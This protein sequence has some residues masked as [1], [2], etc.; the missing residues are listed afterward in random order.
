MTGKIDEATTWFDEHQYEDKE[1][2]YAKQKEIEEV[3]NQIMMKMYQNAGGGEGGIPPG[4]GGMPGGVP[5]D[6]G[7]MA[8][9]GV[10]DGVPD[11]GG[12]A[13]PKIEEV[14]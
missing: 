11:M 14:D 4:M 3:A 6:M 9:G 13:G 1:A 8:S 5:P 2:Y 7:G 10:P 12:D